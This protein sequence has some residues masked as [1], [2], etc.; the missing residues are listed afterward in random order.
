MAAQQQAV[1]A[2]AAAQQQQAVQQQQQAATAAAAQQQAMMTIAAAQPP[3]VQPYHLAMG[4]ASVPPAP[5]SCSMQQLQQLQQP[6]QQFYPKYQ[7]QQP[8]VGA[9]QPMLSQP[10]LSQQPTTLYSNSA[11]APGRP[12]CYASHAGPA[13]APGYVRTRHAYS[14]MM[15]Q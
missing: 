8:F 7:N 5:A 2:A 14:A 9:P 1:A 3:Q 11:S 4:V 12:R 13:V 6:P 15:P 10:M